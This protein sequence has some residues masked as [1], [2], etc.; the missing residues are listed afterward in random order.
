[1]HVS[2]RAVEI[3][4]KEGKLPATKLR[5]RVND[6]PVKQVLIFMADDVEKFKTERDAAVHPD[7]SP[8]TALV[9]TGKPA[10]QHDQFQ[11][12]GIA[13][14][15]QKLGIGET[16]KSNFLTFQEATDEYGLSHAG[17]QQ[18]VDNKRLETFPGKYGRT[19]LS[20]RQIENL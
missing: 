18:L 19:M 15:A 9:A 1:M 5:R 12:L 7:A 4:K 2:V 14:I 8:S 6:E 3:W 20:R 17:W 16:P 11:T 10:Q 13:A